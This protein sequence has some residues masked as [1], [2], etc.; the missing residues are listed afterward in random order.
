[1][2]TI[3]DVRITPGTGGLYQTITTS[4]G[5]ANSKAFSSSSSSS[6]ITII[7][8][9]NGVGLFEGMNSGGA[10]LFKSLIA[11]NGIILAPDATSITISSNSTSKWFAGG[12]APA[13][14]AG[15]IGDFYLNTSTG[16]VYT[17]V[18]ASTWS[19]IATFALAASDFNSVKNIGGGT[20]IFSSFANGTLSLKTVSAGANVVITDNGYGLLTI[21][22]PSLGSTITLSGDIT[23][24]GAGT[25]PT[26][27]RT[28]TSAGT[29]TKVSI[30]E[31]GLVTSGGQLV[32]SDVT[33]ALGYTPVNVG[34]I[35]VAYGVA[36]LDS[37]GKL[38]MSEMPAGLLGAVIYQGVWNASLNV[39]LLVSGVGTKGWYYEVSKAGNTTIDGSTGWAVNDLIIYDGSKWDQ[40]TGGAAPVSSVNSM[41]GDVSIINIIGNA[42]TSTK[43]ASS[44]T[45]S[46]NGDVT[47]TGSF[48]G[49]TNA[50]VAL[51]LASTGF[52]AGSYNTVTVNAKGI[53]T[54]GTYIPYL[55]GLS[56]P[57]TS[58]N[59][60]TGNVTLK[61]TD[62]A[63]WVSATAKFLTFAPVSSVSGRTGAITLTHTDITDWTAA[64]AGFLT[65]A[66]VTYV[67]GRQGSIN[68][69]YRDISGLATVA[70]TGAYADL[71]G[72][73][74]IPA[75][76]GFTPYNATNPA[77]YISSI[78]G[79][80]VTNALGYTPVNKAGDT[81]SGSLKIS[82]T[83]LPT[84]T[85][86]M[87]GYSETEY[88]IA[89]AGNTLTVPV[90]LGSVF[91]FTLSAN[92]TSLV[93]SNPATS[94]FVSSI[95]L[96]STGNGSASTWSGL[97]NVKWAG[98]TAPVLTTTAGKTDIFS[99]FTYNGGTTWYGIV[100][101][102]NF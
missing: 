100:I 82:G 39:P 44:M 19:S 78:T 90:N 38:L 22:V 50:S 18:D 26:T 70:S 71:A 54:S 69:T 41:T 45:L 86:F 73:P 63:D 92:I 30:N 29:Y 66:P 65:S 55:T 37:A 13:T 64:T 51:T 72:L 94:G 93:F 15:N 57:V 97:T 46:Y 91:N 99:F 8:D 42:G 87:G 16:D 4:T 20:S 102:Q 2:G 17:K 6:S 58:V 21:G 7:N 81:I 61:T 31:K 77:G 28:I 74:T 95:I 68:L 35:G 88:P 89:I 101:G 56:A 48:D 24:V 67:A 98:G 85:Q 9:G 11:G 32:S 5:S 23:G 12:V 60:Y 75:P 62:L 83:L 40:I 49:S 76:L 3:A 84:Y 59:G 47:G 53:V 96:M 33:T 79:T 80:M 34:T 43:W 27:L 14:S 10:Y 36:S 1:M 25:I 52:P